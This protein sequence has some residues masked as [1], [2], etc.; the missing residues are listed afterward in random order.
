M[1][2]G[3]LC[4][5]FTEG[6]GYSPTSCQ[7][8][9]FKGLADFFS[10]DDGDIFVINGYAGTGKTT[11]L[12]A[13]INHL[14]KLGIRSVLLAPT[15]RAAK[16]LSGMAH[17][18]AS[19]IHKHIY[20]Q[21]DAGKDG[22]GHFTLCPNK[23][24][25]T[26]FVVDEA[27]LIGREDASRETALFG[28]GDLL[29]DLVEFV[30]AGKG[31]RLVLSGDSA[32]LPPVGL[33]LSPALDL[34]YM[35]ERFG[36]VSGASLSSVVRQES[37]SLILEDATL[38]R[39]TLLSLQS[40]G[41]IPGLKL[42]AFPGREVSRITGSELIDAIS[43]AYDRWGY[44]STV[45]LCRSNS[46]AIRYNLGIRAKVLY[47]EEEISRG[48]KFMIVKN[49]Y[50]FLDD[51]EQLDYIA[52]GD[53]AVLDK[54]WNYESRYGLRFADA[55]LSFPDYDDVEVRAKVLLDTLTSESASL[56]KEQQ[57]ALY[58][59]VSADYADLGNRRKQWQAVREDPYFNA[60]QL[61][62]ADAVTCHKAQGGQWNCVFI[63]CPFW[64]EDLGPDDLKWL[65]TALTRA[66]SQVYLVNFK[67]S[68]FE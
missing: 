47:K 40:S 15:G 29:G 36:G 43:D 60:L 37:E 39:E 58:Q 28:Q 24:S 4:K 55:L 10:S 49:C 45:V 68:F 48:D 23:T 62:Y 56:G 20:R 32:Q 53:I 31:C 44:D 38:V 27:S 5:G 11:A 63:D 46:R 51:V 66:V 18:P 41:S 42:R 14:R 33:D 54:I 3:S 67:D 16:V 22:I 7:E 1:N 64:Q 35:Q 6:L 13:V 52:N 30:R 8:K 34:E 12:S 25:N 26:L 17:R 2:A 21:K 65:Y 9:L 59:G 61:K 19:T 57:D 50:Q